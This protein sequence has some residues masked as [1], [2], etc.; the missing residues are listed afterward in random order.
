M[1]PFRKLLVA[2]RGEIAIRV[3][4]AAHE[5][6]IR[7]VAIYSHEDRFALHRLKADEAYPIGKPGEPLRSY[8][9]IDGIVDIA[10][11]RASTRS[12]PAM[13]FWPR[14]PACRGP[15]NKAGIVVCG[16]PPEVLEQL[17]DKVMARGIAASVKVPILA[18]SNHPLASAE[19]MLKLAEKLGYPVM[20]KAA[21]GG[22][23]RGMRVVTAADELP[24]SLAQAQREALSAFGSDEVFLEKY[25]PRPRHIE[26]QLLGDQHGNL[27]HLYERD[28]SLQRRHQKV[29]ELAPALKLDPEAARPDVPGRARYRPQGEL[30]KRRHRR[31]SARHRYRQV[32]FHRGQPASRSSTR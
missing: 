19:E 12:I 7:T 4:L 9:D 15:A 17:G 18:G 24:N 27:V 29:V 6:G 23:G 1:I 3:F 14:T 10:A 13:A 20:L 11:A 22:G 2:N 5:L 16:P 25:I 26:V 8:L 32:L 30:P 21:K 28:C 31:I